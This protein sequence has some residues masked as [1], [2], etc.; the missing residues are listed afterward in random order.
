MKDML[1]IEFM[2]LTNGLPVNIDI[3]T[4]DLQE[5]GTNAM[6]ITQEIFRISN[7]KAGK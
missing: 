1:Y 5:L 4:C 2:E 3:L 6:L 7:L